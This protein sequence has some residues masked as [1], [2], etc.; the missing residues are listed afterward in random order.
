MQDPKKQRTHFWI[1]NGL[2][3]LSL[4]SLFFMDPLSKA[5]GIGA[6]VLWM[7]LAGVGMYFIMLDKGPKSDHLD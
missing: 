2:L 5:L 6:M 7:S 4:A 1:G 3:A